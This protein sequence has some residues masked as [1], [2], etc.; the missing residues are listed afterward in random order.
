MRFAELVRAVR[1]SV[2]DRMFTSAELAEHAD[3]APDLRAA[4]MGAVGAVSPRRIGKL[5]RRIEGQDFGGASI[6]RVGS[7]NSGIVWKVSLVS[8]AQTH[9]VSFA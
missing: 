8:K 2:R 4:I 3:L 7:D 9:S 6:S 5:L 1:E